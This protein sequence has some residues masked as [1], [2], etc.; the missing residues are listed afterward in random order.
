MTN[1][2]RMIGMIVPT[3][4]NPFFASLACEV[5][6][7]LSARQ[8]D[9]LLCGSANSAAREKEYF[10]MLIDKGAAGI[11]C[12]SGLS[13][14]PDGLLPEDYPLV[15]LDRRP[16][17]S[18]AVPWVANDDAAA[19]EAATEYLL[20]KGCRNILLLPGFLAEQQESPRVV[21]Y[22]RALEK[23]GIAFREKYVL[24]RGGRKPS[25]TETEEL[26][27]AL[28]KDGDAI[29]GVI[30]SSDRS[31]FGAMTALRKV[32]RYAPEDVK[33]ICFDNSPYSTMASPSITAL[34]RNPELLAEKGCETLLQI[35][36]KSDAINFETIVPVSLVQRDSTR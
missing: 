15:W 9:L 4:D 1:E 31:A 23:R 25:E 20:D 11:L 35:L 19:T 7:F 2:K 28:L 10:R 27:L 34:D 14:L 33:L 24:R 32:G 6:Q 29:D 16:E 13:A 26:M 30:A 18:R 5:E 3:V 36:N 17:A 22:R 8:Y 21:G 12:V